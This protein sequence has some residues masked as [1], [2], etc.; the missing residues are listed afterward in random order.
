SVRQLMSGISSCVSRGV[1]SWTTLIWVL[2]SLMT[3]AAGPSMSGNRNWRLCLA[4]FT[5]FPKLKDDAAGQ[6]TELLRAKLWDGS[7][8]V[9]NGEPGL[10]VI[11]AFLQIPDAQTCGKLSTQR[12][13]SAK[14]SDHSLLRYWKSASANISAMLL[15]IPSCC[16]S[17][18]YFRRKGT[19]CPQ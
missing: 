3:S 1:S 19:P 8:A 14:N 2:N 7:R 10:L 4:K 6:Q 9:W 16:R 5:T 17:I 18:R 12:S 11:V 15:R 13:S